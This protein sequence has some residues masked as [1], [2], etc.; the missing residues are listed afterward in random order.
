MSYTPPL[1]SCKNRLPD[2]HS[3]FSCGV[4]FR[5][6]FE[7]IKLMVKQLYSVTQA[8]FSIGGDTRKKKKAGVSFHIVCIHLY[9]HEESSAVN[10]NGRELK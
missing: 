9:S 1:R 8:S 5:A 4:I 7:S 2:T 6:K 3:L 10:L